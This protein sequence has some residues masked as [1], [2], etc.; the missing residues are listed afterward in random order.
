MEHCGAREGNSNGKIVR[1]R[2]VRLA[3]KLIVAQFCGAK[4]Q[5]IINEGA[6]CERSENAMQSSYHHQ[7]D[8]SL[9]PCNQSLGKCIAGQ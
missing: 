8:T 3:M 7:L 5:E 2:L 6:E 9:L 4:N 1:H